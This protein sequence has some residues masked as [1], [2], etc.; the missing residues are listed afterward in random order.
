MKSINL[1]SF[2]VLLLF[3]L[4]LSACR[5]ASNPSLPLE[6]PPAATS[7][8]PQRQTAPGSA[9]PLA[10]SP[11]E[12]DPRAAPLGA[13]PPAALPE[14][15]PLPR[16]VFL[17]SWDGGSA[18]RVYDLMQAGYLPHFAALA[19]QGLRAEYA[20]S[21]DPP[22]TGPAQNSLATGAFPA[23]TGIVS[24]AFH[25]PNDSFYWYRQGL[26]EPLDAAE[27]VWVTASRAGL[28]TAA[29]FFP[30][31]SPERP[32]QAADYTIGY[33]VRDA[34]S[35]QHSLE[36]H[37]VAGAW[38]GH[39][40]VSFSPPQEGCFQIPEV[41]RVY[42]YLLDS[43]DD[44]QTVYDT[45]L[46]NTT[47]QIDEQTPRLQV[48]EWGSL[49]L[50]PNLYAGAEF[51]IQEIIQGEAPIKV[52]FFQTGVYHNTA[53]P[54]PLLEGLN[55]E[56]GFF[57]AGPDFYA[58]EH[59]WITVEDNLYLLERASRWMAGVAAWVY[60]RYR[61]DLLFTWQDG[62][63][64]AG[65]AFTLVDPRQPD[66]SAERA[67]AAA[68]YYR[69]AA[70]L[71]DQ[72]LEIMLAPLD[73]EYT[74]VMLVSDHGMAPVHTTV[75]PNTL[76]ERSGLLVLDRR[77]Y[78]VEN[79]S[80]AIAFASGGAMH[81]YIHLEGRERNG[82]VSVEAYPR[83]Q[84]QVVELL[85]GLLDP[86]SGEPVFQRVLPRSELASLGLDHPNSGDI[87]AQANPGYVLDGWRG[88]D[89]VFAP[90]STCGQHGYASDLPAMHALFIA[91]GAGVP[92][93]GEV[94]PGVRLVDCAPTIAGLL[95]F[96]PAATVDGHPIPAFEVKP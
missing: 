58:L 30:G 20:Q 66:Y 17:I 78:V 81:V 13:E 22:L 38:S 39:A 23:R 92:G 85:S 19:G 6:N 50:L 55:Q 69:R 59:G 82:T 27:P 61:P 74:T 11:A 3:S 72:A 35:K 56:F 83:V 65:H 57:Q 26:E 29:V 43:R 94:I 14:A 52:T 15:D 16:S 10:I 48:G 34:Y 21:V 79:K 80:Q 37:P 24:N 28:T 32:L 71:A 54:R 67:E 60:A 87:F 42:L 70:Q 2:L 46:L 63:D 93:G 7:P 88:N 36:L 18:G 33:G 25:N 8:A 86:D 40:P 84:Q 9:P 75:Y 45:V 95:G 4:A 73:L 68:G 5:P 44:D 31:G 90:A 12:N 49:V 41:T 91:A 53:A 1:P 51:L 76:L 62:F 77:D 64:A 47:R 89:F 96:P